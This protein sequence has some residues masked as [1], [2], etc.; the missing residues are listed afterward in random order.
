M[1]LKPPDLD[2]L[3]HALGDVMPKV[4]PELQ[5]AGLEHFRLLAEGRPVSPQTLAQHLGVPQELVTA[6]LAGQTMPTNPA[7]AS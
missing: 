5:R 1:N 2:A 6:G 4:P 7:P 3:A